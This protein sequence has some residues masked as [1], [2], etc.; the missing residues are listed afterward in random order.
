MGEHRL[1]QFVFSPPSLTSFGNLSGP[2][3]L[4]RGEEEAGPSFLK[5]EHSPGLVSLV[6]LSQTGYT[7]RSYKRSGGGG[8]FL[9]QG[10]TGAWDYGPC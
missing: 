8:T 6:Q 5:K 9:S 10:L 7:Y 2:G 4:S 1:S 3:N